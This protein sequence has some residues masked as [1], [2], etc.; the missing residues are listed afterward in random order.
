MMEVGPPQQLV[1]EDEEDGE[2]S[3]P[4]LSIH[5]HP[6]LNWWLEEEEGNGEGVM[7]REERLIHGKHG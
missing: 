3:N 1:K 5:M 7:K 4:F 6:L 2:I